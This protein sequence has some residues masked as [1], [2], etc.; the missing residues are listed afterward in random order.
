MDVIA[1]EANIRLGL[2]LATLTCF[3][4]LSAL[5]PRR[6]LNVSWWQRWFDNIGIT[7]VNTIILR[8]LF[9]AAAVG[10]AV[11]TNELGWGLMNWLPL[12]TWLAVIL[13]AVLLD[14]LIYWQHVIFHRVPLLWRLHKV[15]HTDLDIDVTTGF[16]FHP[17]EIVLSMLI[18]CLAIVVL[19]APALGVLLFEIILS[20]CAMFNHSNLRLPL[21]MDA[22]LRK[23]IVTP[24]MH[25]VHHSNLPYETDSNFG[26]SLSLWDRLFGSY[27]AQPKSGHTAMTI[28]LNEYRQ[29]SHLHLPR[30]LRL[31]FENPKSSSE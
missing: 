17:V 6:Q 7:A 27:R 28:G 20:L 10:V 16:R 1:N 19:G 13:T 22:V 2:F 14:L 29:F 12:P 23:L 8:L 24:D 5:F 3:G 9:P 31:P 30:L 25:R 15:H 11:Y 4:V 26:F 18:K 21:A